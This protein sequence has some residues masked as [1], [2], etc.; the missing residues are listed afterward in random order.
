MSNDDEKEW[1][2]LCELA[3][4]ETDHQKLVELA[5]RINS[6][7]EQRENKLRSK[8]NPTPGDSTGA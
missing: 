7:L 1:R 3:A 4:V 8:I 2:E 6:L 5:D